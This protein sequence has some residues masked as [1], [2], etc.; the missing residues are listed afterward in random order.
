MAAEAQHIVWC[1]LLVGSWRTS[2][3]REDWAE[4]G[5]VQCTAASR[6]DLPTVEGTAALY[7]HTDQTDLRV[8]RFRTINCCRYASSHGAL[9]SEAVAR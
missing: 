9:D 8:Q 6:A 4:P 2:A 1:G 3:T 7:P 5:K